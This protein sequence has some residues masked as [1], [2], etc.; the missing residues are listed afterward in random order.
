MAGHCHH[1]VSLPQHPRPH[2][3]CVRTP[4]ASA[5][6][7]TTAAAVV[8]AHGAPEAPQV[9]GAQLSPA[10]R[11]QQLAHGVRRALGQVPHRRA[12]QVEATARLRGGDEAGG[13][14][15]PVG[16]SRIPRNDAPGG[17]D[18]V[19]AALHAAVGRVRHDLL[20]PLDAVSGFLGDHGEDVAAA[21]RRRKELRIIRK[22]LPEA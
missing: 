12:P 1:P 2:R 9:G 14:R 7:V 6:S 21:T 20:T 15:L 4:S 5:A 22:S 8:S 13:E 10:E 11:L 19:V 17:G 16:R 3:G 18:G